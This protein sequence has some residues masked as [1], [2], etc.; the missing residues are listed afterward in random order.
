MRV[1]A[2]LFDLGDTLVDTKDFDGWA[3]L[4]RRFYLDLDPDVLLHSYFEVENAVDERP[5]PEGREAAL[6]DFWQKTLSS[7]AAKPVDGE[8]TRK[9]IA[10]TREVERPVHLYS[11]VRR[12][13]DTLRSERRELGVVSNS[14]SEASVRRILD[15]AG[16]LEYFSRILSSGTEGVEKPDPAIFRRAVERMN[17]RPEE[18]VYVGN[19]AFTDAKAAGAAGLHGVWLN[20]EGC[21][22]GE[23]PP[24]IISLLELPLVVHRLENGITTPRGPTAG[25]AR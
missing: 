5:H 15:R 18:T 3:E 23:D 19:L 21:G 20:R 8:T 17:V 13:L 11:D 14:T 10:A 4:A 9:F 25:G 16:I 24:E 2:V 22:Y 1:R 12:C 7:A 6:V